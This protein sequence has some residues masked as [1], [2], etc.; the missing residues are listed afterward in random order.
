MKVDTET[1]TSGENEIDLKQLLNKINNLE[2][3]NLSMKKRIL[4]L[5]NKLMTYM[6]KKFLNINENLEELFLDNNNKETKIT[7]IE[8]QIYD[9]ENKFN[10]KNY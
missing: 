9:L 8:N 5:E 1:E 2:K 6:I 7:Q 10:D 3:E 4:E